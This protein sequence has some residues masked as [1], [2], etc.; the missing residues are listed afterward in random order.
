MRSRTENSIKNSTIALMVQGINVFLNFITRTIFIKYLGASYLGVNGLFSNILSVLSFAELGFGTAIIYMMYEPIAKDDRKKIAALLNFYRK[1]YIF[2]GTMILVLGTILIPGLPFFINNSSEIPSTLPPLAFVYFLYLLNS[3]SSYFF[4]YKRSII[5]ASQNGYMDSLNTLYFNVLRNILQCI[6]L[7]IGHSF[8]GYLLIQIVCT[9]LA[10]VMMSKKVD[11][12]FPYLQELKKEKLDAKSLKMIKRN[13]IAMSMHKL[14]S[15]IVSGT[16]NILISKFVGLVATG[17]YSNYV[18]LTGTIKTVYTQLFSPVTASVGNLLALKEEDKIKDFTY[19]ILFINAVIA[20][21]CTSCLATLANPFIQ[22]FW[23]K[24]YLFDYGTV[25]L[26]MI[27]FYLNCMRQSMTVMIDAGGLFWYNKWKGIIEA[28]INLVASIT[29]ASYLNMG[30]R[31]IVL[32]T[33]ISNVL[34]NLWW[35]PYVVYKYEVKDS[36]VKYF[37]EYAKYFIT[38]ILATAVTIGL[39]HSIKLSIKTFIVYCMISALVPIIIITILYGRSEN[40]KY[41]Y[42]LVIDKIIKKAKR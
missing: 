12:M 17:C 1:V 11:K 24:K 40:Y 6:V 16:D 19:K 31:G 30:I 25:A 26:I 5:I 21:F 37:F 36:L 8:I 3:S 13:V 7:F 4:N 42:K 10:N 27:S 34:T 33:I 28:V 23:G 18:M 39:Q 35:D 20:I 38:L 29:L 22:L 14:S 41:C 9:L 15:V 2:V 32:G